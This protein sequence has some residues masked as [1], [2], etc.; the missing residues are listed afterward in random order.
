MDSRQVPVESPFFDSLTK[1][2]RFWGQ[3]RHTSNK[4]EN[5]R[6]A[7]PSLPPRI[8]GVFGSSDEVPPLVS[9]DSLFVP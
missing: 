9:L 6:V 8:G 3:V 1:V 4:R 5:G 7:D 2:V